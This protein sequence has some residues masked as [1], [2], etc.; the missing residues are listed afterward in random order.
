MTVSGKSFIDG[1]VVIAYSNNSEIS[2]STID[3][4][5]IFLTSTS[6]CNIT[7]NTFKN[8][9]HTDFSGNSVYI[10]PYGTNNNVLNNSIEILSGYG[11]ACYSDYSSIAGNTVVN[12]NGT[13]ITMNYCSNVNVENNTINTSGQVGYGIDL[14]SSP[15]NRI[16][17][18]T[19][20]TQNNRG[21]SIRS[22]SSSSHLEDNTIFI[23][24]NNAVGI[25][26]DSSSFCKI[27]KNTI[28]TIGYRSYGIRLED[29]SN[30]NKI[31]NN[32]ILTTGERAYGISIYQGTLL[33]KNM[34]VKNNINTYGSRGYGIYIYQSSTNVLSNNKINTYGT[35]G[36][37]VY[38]HQSSNNDI[39]NNE[40]NTSVGGY[41]V[42]LYQN[43]NY[44]D[45]I[46]NQ[47][48][49]KAQ[50]GHGIYIYN[51]TGNNIINCTINT[52]GTNATGFYLNKKLANII[53]STLSTKSF[54]FDLKATN[55]AQITAINCNF[56]TF[57]LTSDGGGV[58]KVMNYLTIQVFDDD[59]IT[60]IPNVDVEVRDNNNKVYAS[61]G[62]SGTDTKTNTMGAVDNIPVT[63]RM[64]YYNTIPL[65]N[66]TDIKVKK[67]FITIWEASRSNIDMSKSHTEIF[68]HDVSIPPVPIGLR[69]TRVVGTNT[70]NISW[71]LNNDTIKYV[72]YT[73]RSGQWEILNSHIHPKNWT[74]DHDLVDNTWYYYKIL[75]YDKV[76]LSSGLSNAVSYYLMDLTPPVIPRGLTVSP[77]PAGDALN[78]SWIENP[79]N[80]QYYNIFWNSTGSSK[81]G[82][83][84]NISHPKNF[85]I[86]SDDKLINGSKYYFKIQ[87][88]YQDVSPSLHSKLVTV[89]HRDY[90]APKAPS[91]LKANPVSESIIELSWK[92]IE[93]PDVEGYLVF[94]NESG[95]G[96]NK[97]FRFINKVYTQSYKATGLNENTEYFFVIKAFDEANN[98]SPYS[99]E[100]RT[101]TL[102]TPIRPQIVLTIPEQNSTEMKINNSVQIT[103]NIPM[104]VETVAKVLEVIPET[105]FN[106]AWINDNTTL[107]INFKR[108]LTH[109]TNYTIIIGMAKSETG[110]TLVNWP[111][112]L[113][114]RTMEKILPPPILKKLEIISINPSSNIKPG[115]IISISGTSAGFNEG[116]MIKVSVADFTETSYIGSDG[117]WS[118]GIEAP[119]IKGNY[120]IVV[121]LGNLSE[122]IPITIEPE[123]QSKPD[124]DKK[125][126][127]DKDNGLFGM[128]SIMELV[129]IIIII[130][131]ILIIWLMFFSRRKLEE[132]VDED[133]EEE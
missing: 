119:G 59:S 21:F 5:F 115:I 123:D 56:D 107:Q 41:G 24:R 124:V 14:W 86:F 101:I 70:L 62:Y 122:S 54:S 68:Y 6:N 55:D 132:V 60:P 111:F 112:V 72:V 32:A 95:E 93:D 103:F 73:N 42:F 129:I 43:S 94:L 1:G 37:G 16:K 89:I 53:N 27:I 74:L 88:V 8:A 17:N 31:L 125:D 58:L 81:W 71:N 97:I 75:A 79:D 113:N 98:T 118:I 109:N 128:G 121:S 83:I 52:S 9:S 11:I 108:N 120:T 2:N 45:L 22:G 40:I 51:A 13:G 49:T 85:F 28:D 34:L 80:T 63:D 90:L 7:H 133:D 10:G 15:D 105:N 57:Q 4:F 76:D 66:N 30:N 18:N 36:D 104:N 46:Q 84:V 131:M 33:A 3:S 19:L 29:S 87:A 67:S 130:I 23:N 35:R 92:Q 78:I 117:N 91:N 50:D 77:V 69:V 110:T 12:Y 39:M 25:T 116:T 47:I 114:F 100:A 26:L 20:Y 64:Y 38:I 106:L 82:L 44:N 126:N 96:A 48:K 102:E 65:E 99:V 61:S 127:G